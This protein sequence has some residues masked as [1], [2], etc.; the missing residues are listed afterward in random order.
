MTVYLGKDGQ[1]TT[2]DD[3]VDALRA[4]LWDDPRIDLMN[5]RA[6][7]A[8]RSG[9]VSFALDVRGLDDSAQW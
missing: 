6:L 1:L 9:A 4:V 2:L 5:A 3:Q 8:W 7:E